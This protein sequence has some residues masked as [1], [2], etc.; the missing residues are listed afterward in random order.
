MGVY[1]LRLFVT[2]HGLGVH[3]MDDL[4]AD[5]RV[6]ISAILSTTPRLSLILLV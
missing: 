2:G 3:V 1:N 5:H 6:A 4:R